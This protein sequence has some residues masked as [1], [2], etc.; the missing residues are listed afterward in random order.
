M[1]TLVGDILVLFIYIFADDESAY[2]FSPLVS[3]FVLLFFFFPVL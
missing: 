1:S 2:N 3:R